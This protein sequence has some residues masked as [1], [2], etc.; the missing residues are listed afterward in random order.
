M[1]KRFE[2]VRQFIID[3]KLEDP[4][5]ITAKDLSVNTGLFIQFMEDYLGRDVCRTKNDSIVMCCVKVVHV[6]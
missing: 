3:Q 6:V 5:N 4:R 1:C 2:P